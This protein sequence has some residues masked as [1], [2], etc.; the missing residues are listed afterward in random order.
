MS[1]MQESRRKRQA[2]QEECLRAYHAGDP[3]GDVGILK[4]AAQ[5][6]PLPGAWTRGWT[7]SA[8]LSRSSS[9]TRSAHFQRARSA[10]LPRSL[11]HE[12]R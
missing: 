12:W 6:E 3:I 7:T 8:V 10:A 9:W 5:S 4:F 1:P 2:L 11:G